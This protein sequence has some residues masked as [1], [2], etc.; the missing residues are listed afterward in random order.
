MIQI[1]AFINSPLRKIFLVFGKT[2]LQRKTHPWKATGK[3]EDETGA[4]KQKAL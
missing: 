1:F 2:A 3:K 4:G